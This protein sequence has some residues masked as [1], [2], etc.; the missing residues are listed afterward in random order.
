MENLQASTLSDQRRSCPLRGNW[1]SFRLVDEFGEGKPYAG[2]AYELSDSEGEKKTGVLDG[3]GFARVEGNYSGPAILTL[4][5]IYTGTDDYYN[6]LISRQSFDIP[7]TE[8]QVAAEQTLRRAIGSTSKTG[9]YRASA[10]KGVYYNVEVRDFVEFSRHLPPASK[11]S[12]PIPAG[13]AKLVRDFADNKVPS[14]GVGLLPETHYVLEVRALRAFRPLLSL[15][16]EFSAL[17]LYQL[18]LMGT[19]SYG[20]FGQVPETLQSNAKLKKD[21]AFSYPKRGTIGH[22]L[23]TCFACYEEPT[24]YADSKQAAY[25][26][27]EDVPYSKR[28]EVVPFDPDRYPQNDA[29]SGVPLETPSSVHFFNDARLG[30]TDWKN[31]DTQAYATHDDRLVL[32]G[33]R[34][35]AEGWDGWRDADAQ[36]VPIEG[37]TGKAHQGFYEAFVALRPFIEGYMR[38]FRRNQKILVCGHSLGGAIALLLAEWLRQN[39]T[40]DVILY[41][42]GSPRAGDADFVE[43]AKALVH[44][45]IVNHNDPVPSVPAGWMDT[46]KPIWF[47]GLAATVSGVLTPAAGG[48]VFAAGMARFGGKPYWH[49]GEQRHFMPLQLPGRVVS[50]VLWKP[51]CEGYEEA[52]MARCVAQMKKND[53]PDRSQFMSQVFSAADHKMLDGYIPSCWASLRRW[54]ETQTTGGYVISSTESNRL[55][56]EVETYRTELQK[57]QR[58]ADS[59]FPGGT[60]EGRPQERATPL[61]RRS[62]LSDLQE[63]QTAINQA[64]RHNKKELE[65]IE[66]TLQRLTSL[67]STKLTIVDVYGDR[68]ELPELK[69][70]IDRWAAHTEN[71]ASVRLAQIPPSI[72]EH[73]A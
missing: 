2:L 27:V 1:I 51:G 66:L 13:C 9:A 37:G 25:P 46:K 61:Q 68:S 43:G 4:S 48:L 10:E 69:T 6:Y 63:R 55:K 42:F 44:H 21:F 3:D 14:F 60:I 70:H 7:L 38:R 41:T 50:S 12:N 56:L 39:I 49:H 30:T 67:S 72:S 59:E 8:L 62:T 71:Q 73:M 35:T 54:Q 65:A 24:H 45:R 17:N 11:L 26:L 29:T 36:Q 33:V 47:T 64:V 19:L 52:A 34:G 32:I 53:M 5:K 18:S 20:A 58:N 23:N 31:T 22:V 16:N 28:L 15:A 57:W 40:D